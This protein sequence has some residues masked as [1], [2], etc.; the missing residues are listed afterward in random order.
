MLTF[1][2]IAADRGIV[3][4][5]DSVGFPA[6]LKYLRDRGVHEGLIDDLGIKILPAAEL[7][8]RSRGT[9]SQDD[10]LAVVIP[11]FSV[12]GDYINWWSARLVD[13]GLR[14]V[15]HSLASLVPAKRGKMF[16]PPNEPPHAYLPPILDWRKLSRGDK[17]YI[18][19]SCIKAINGARL[20]YWSV[21]LNGV[22]GWGS[23]K[24][25]LALVTELRDLP[26]KA[27]EL[28]PII[29]FDSNA[30]DNWDVQAAISQLA[31]KLLEITGQHA[32]HILLPR[33][34]GGAHQGF[35][36]FC[37]RN[38]DDAASEFLEQ[39]GQIVEVSGVHLMKIKLNAEVVVVRSLGRI[40]EQATGTL[41]SRGTFTDVNY[42]HYTA[43]IEDRWVNVPKLWLA[44]DRRSE[45][46]AITYKPGQPILTE[47][48]L[49][50]W[51]S[52]GL[53][54]VA[55]DVSMWLN[56]IEK[57]IPDEA[58]RKWVIQWMAYPLQNLGC[59]LN[60]YL[61]LYGPPGSGKQAVIAPLMR[62]YGKQNSVVIGKREV[63]S[64]FN[65][66][67]ANKQF[68][69]IDELHASNEQDKIANKIKMLTTG[70]DLVVNTKGQP[71]Y[72]VPNVANFVSTS[73]Y[74]DSLKLDDDD[75]RAC[76]IQ[77]GKRGEG[78][79]KVFWMRYFDWVDGGGAAAVY[80]YLLKV[81]L[82]GFNPKGW[83]PMTEA[84]G[85]ATRATRRVDEQ[86]VNQL[87]DDP[88]ELLP[89]VLEGRCLMTTDE[90][91]RYCY[92]DDPQGVTPG[93]KNSLGIK[94]HTAGFPKVEVKVDGKKVRFWVVRKQTDQWGPEAVR[95]HLKLHG[96]PGV[97]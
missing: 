73:N 95:A 11:H 67:Y 84:K 33:D 78:E 62:A 44:D 7:I 51:R 36:D 58:L 34:A 20:G 97:K 71:E 15:V 22:W 31:A 40:A 65:S 60:S 79:D 29:V 28:K 63:S 68:I 37:V 35:D 55:G 9:S 14:P 81:D 59:K 82:A 42:A 48:C 52:M 93:K 56:L 77:F 43:E 54:P 5:I 41:M 13:T 74:P 23:R 76:V 45:V 39:E 92:G 69:N 18:H 1:P 46:E 75:R 27:L 21:G 16:C 50:M 6:V 57:N 83:A 3:S 8:R 90:L 19:E 61:H 89:P 96:Y 91:A 53:E 80:D 70:E 2:E 26:W 38:G 30:D 24:H 88:D 66:I 12:Q 85:E 47:D 25:N 72:S 87:W 86:W 64:D 10:R 32:T 17:I 49:N 94:L 4:E